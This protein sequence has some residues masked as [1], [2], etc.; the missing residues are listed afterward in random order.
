MRYSSLWSDSKS[1][2]LRNT[3]RGQW[4]WLWSK[5]RKCVETSLMML[6]SMV[7]RSSNDSQ[8]QQRAT[9]RSVVS[10]Q[11][12]VHEYQAYVDLRYLLVLER[13]WKAAFQIERAFDKTP[14]SPTA[15]R[16]TSNSIYCS[17]TSHK[18]SPPK[19]ICCH[20]IPHESARKDCDS[21]NPWITILSYI[22]KSTDSV[23]IQLLYCF[24]MKMSQICAY[25]N[26]RPITSHARLSNPIISG[27]K[28]SVEM[29]NSF[30]CEFPNLP[31]SSRLS[32]LQSQ[33]PRVRNTMHSNVICIL[34]H[35]I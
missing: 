2:S 35:G 28:T 33:G 4:W 14:N 32:N 13:I 7:L 31:G 12:F 25:N 16:V 8:Q 27:N 26:V 24:S 9:I 23:I 11:Y 5:K 3:E 20:H 17:I 21:M 18:T 15:N 6:Y 19:T 22:K 29:L 1:N 34:K 30:R 10:I